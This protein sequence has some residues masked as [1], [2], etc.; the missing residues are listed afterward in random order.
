MT[1]IVNENSARKGH[2]SY[3][4]GIHRKMQINRSKRLLLCLPFLGLGLFAPPSSLAQ[5]PFE[6]TWRINLEQSKPVN[7]SLVISMSKGFYCA[8]SAEI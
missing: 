7:K 5:G 2:S 3:M 8:G 6:G 1:V 4:T